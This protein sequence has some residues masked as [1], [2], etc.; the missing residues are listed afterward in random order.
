MLLYRK[1][2]PLRIGLYAG[3]TRDELVPLSFGSFRKKS[4]DEENLMAAL[5]KALRDDELG[6]F[7]N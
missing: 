7:V 3:K 5:K 2:H 4:A 6:L 1:A